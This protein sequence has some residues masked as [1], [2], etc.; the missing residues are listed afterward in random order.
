MAGLNFAELTKPIS[1]DEPCGPDLEDDL[2]FMNAT[3]RLEVA[4]VQYYGWALANRDALLPTRAQLDEATRT[5]AA[6]REEHR[7]RLVIDR[8]L[9]APMAKFA[10]SAARDRL[11]SS[12][13]RMKSC[14]VVR[15][16]IGYR[17]DRP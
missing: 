17:A 5:V 1:A 12:A 7:G 15:L 13:T 14:R 2:D 3:A 9:I 8:R 10:S 6:A 4:H 11:P 16:S